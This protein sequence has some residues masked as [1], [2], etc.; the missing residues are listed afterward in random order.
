[1]AHSTRR[2]LCAVLDGPGAV[3]GEHVTKQGM[4]GRPNPWGILGWAK[5]LPE[6]A[7]AGL[8]ALAVLGALAMLL[9][10]FSDDE[11]QQSLVDT[12]EPSAW[13]F[14][15]ICIVAL[16]GVGCAVLARVA[17][18]TRSRRRVALLQVGVMLASMV[19]AAYGHH[20]LMRRTTQ[21]T[22]QTFGG[23]P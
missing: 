5:W 17:S 10:P 1:M 16:A 18:H 14:I 21:L 15:A 13:N 3:D 12:Y 20:R 7:N 4:S 22:G 9:Q 2:S 11:I 8:V 19:L 23:F 6:V